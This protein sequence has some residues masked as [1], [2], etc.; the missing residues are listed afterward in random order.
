MKNP[1]FAGVFC[2][3]IVLAVSCGTVEDSGLAAEMRD[4]A[5]EYKGITVLGEDCGTADF[6]LAVYTPPPD[7]TFRSL[8]DGV[9]ADT[10][11]TQSEFEI[12]ENRLIIQIQDEYVLYNESRETKYYVMI[13]ELEKSVSDG[14][15]IEYG[16]I[17][18]HVEG[19]NALLVVFSET[20]DP[21]LVINSNTPPVHYAGYFWFSPS[22][23]S[24]TG[25]TRWITFDP[26]DSIEN[27]LIKIAD[28]VSEEEPGLALYNQRV[29][30]ET[31]LSQYPRNITA[32]ERDAISLYEMF[33]YGRSGIIS[34][35]NEINAGAYT[36]LLCWQNGFRDYL[37]REYVPNDDIWLYGVIVTYNVWE[38]RGYIFLRDFTPVSVE[39]I[40]QERM[41]LLRGGS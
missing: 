31:K 30:F 41:D 4:Q 17:I 14:M 32:K 1:G 18:G 21:Y 7:R 35:V 34:H 39:E 2:F 11:F 23:L 25:N 26:F 40:Y 6:P 12:F 33:L 29:R 8:F 37:Q 22:F 20:L 15:L 3:L 19:A 24:P 28:H 36:Y 38:E 13:F 16:D 27:E 5:W 9:V 10:F